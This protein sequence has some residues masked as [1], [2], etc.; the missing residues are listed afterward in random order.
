MA[1][2]DP[3]IYNGGKYSSIDIDG[4]SQLQDFKW[5]KKPLIE[6]QKEQYFT[7]LSSTISMPKHFGQTIKRHLYVPLLDDRNVNDQGIDAAGAIISPGSG[8]LYGSSRDIGTITKSLP[9]LGE[10]GGRVNRVGF[11]RLVLEAKIHKMGFFFEWSQ[12][13][14][15]FDSDE[16]LYSHLSREALRGATQMY[17]AVLQKDLLEGVGVEMYAGE[18]TDFDEMTAEGAT[19]SIVTYEDLAKLDQILTDNR[20]P[21]QTTIITGTRNIDT[22][23]VPSCRVMYVGSEV[24]QLL[25]NMIHS[26]GKNLEQFAFVGVEHYAAGTTLLRGEIGKIGNFRVIQVPEMLYWAGVGAA[27]G[28]NPGYR[29]T[30]GKYNVYPMLVVGD[31]SF[32]TISFQVSDGAGKFKFMTQKPG[33]ETMGR[34]D[35]YG[36]V[37]RTSIQW[38]YGTMINRPERLAVIYTVAPV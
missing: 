26:G 32:N 34:D 23:V 24:A 9:V 37:G 6:A 33:K 14:L 11:T 5:L 20:C 38:W 3:M 27:E 1:E 21:K 19:P 15:Q 29:V 17:E 12:D 2:H 31:D 10:L 7:Q 8:N 25:Q 28:T 18:A 22:K 36:Q 35:P 30:D 4:Q 16:A 13:A